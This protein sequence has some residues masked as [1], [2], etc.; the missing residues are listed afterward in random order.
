MDDPLLEQQYRDGQLISKECIWLG[1]DPHFTY[2]EFEE[3]ADCHFRRLRRPM[4]AEEIARR[5]DMF[6]ALCKDFPQYWQR[7]FKKKRKK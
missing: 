4:T 5:K 1:D 2:K 6:S 7:Y 3:R